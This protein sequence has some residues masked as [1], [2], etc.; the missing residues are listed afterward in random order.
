MAG[1]ALRDDSKCKGDGERGGEWLGW[2]SVV[3]SVA[4]RGWR[5]SQSDR[6]FLGKD[7]SNAQLGRRRSAVLVLEDHGIKAGVDVHG[8]LMSVA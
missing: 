5:R 4:T 1:Y 8:L 6:R 2:M 7:L 3:H